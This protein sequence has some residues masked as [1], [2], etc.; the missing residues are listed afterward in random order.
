MQRMTETARRPTARS[1]PLSRPAP[2]MLVVLFPMWLLALAMQ[3][4]AAESPVGLTPEL[5]L[6]AAVAWVLSSTSARAQAQAQRQAQSTPARDQAASAS[7]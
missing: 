4:V 2:G 3:A 5:I 1:L 7:E 6:A